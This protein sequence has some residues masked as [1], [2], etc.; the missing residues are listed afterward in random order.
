M[1]IQYTVSYYTLK[2]IRKR[3]HVVAT[4][5]E[6]NCVGTLCGADLSDKRWIFAGNGDDITCPKCLRAMRA[7]KQRAP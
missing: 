7:A 3:V 2:K 6:N 1:E 4:D 5:D